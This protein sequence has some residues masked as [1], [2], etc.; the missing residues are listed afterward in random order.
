ML[1]YT[2]TS[3]AAL[4]I[5]LAAPAFA[6]DAAPKAPRAAPVK[7]DGGIPEIVVTAQKRAENVQNVPISITAFT[8]AALTE[9]GVGD[10]AALSAI[11]PNVTLDS[12]T[13]FSGSSAVLGASIRGIGSADF[14]FN[15]D[16]A[17]GVYLD[18]VYLGRSVGANQDLLDVERI[19]V[20]KGPQGTL[21]GRN[22]IGGAVSIVTHDP[23]KE[24][25]FKGDITTGSYNR[26]QVRGTADIP[27][28]DNLTSSI[29][30]SMSRRD[31]YQHRIAYPGTIV[32]DPYTNFVAAGY[33]NGGNRQGG[34]NSYS[35]R[36]KLKY[37]SGGLKAILS[38]DYT[39]INSESTANTLLATTTGGTLNDIYNACATLP[40]AVSTAI[41]NY[42]CG[43]RTSV[44]GFNTAPG[45]AGA[46]Y[47]TYGSQFVTSDK[48]TT[49][50]NG[51][52]YSRVKQYGIG[53]TLEQRISDNAA[54][55]SITAYRQV[56]FNAGV[57]LDG[58]PLNMLQT[59]FTVNQH[60]W[61][62]EFQLNGTSSDKKLNYTFGVY[63]FNEVGGLHDYVTFA[64]GLLQV[65]GPGRINTVALAGYGQID[66]RVSDLIGITVG[67]RYTHER[68]NY[69]GGQ[70]DDNAFGYKISGC[71]PIAQC[72][73]GTVHVPGAPPGVNFPVGGIG[74][75]INNNNSGMFQY[76]SNLG[77]LVQYI[78]Y[79]PSQPNTL[80]FNN[81]SPK[82]GIQL[83]PS[84]HV[85]AY[86]SWS[87]GYRSGGWTTRLSNPLLVAPTFGPEKAQT[88]EVGI[89]SQLADRKLQVN[90]ALFTTNYNGIQL[91]QQ[92]GISPTVANLGI[93]RSRGFEL[94][95]VAAPTRQ[96]T[97]SGSVG[98]LDAKYTYICGENGVF[99]GFCNN[100]SAYVAPDAYRPGIASGM[101]LPKAPKWK[102]NISPR[103]EIETGGG[104]L[105]VLADYTHTSK[106]RNDTEG[107]YLLERRETDIV[108]ASL[109]YKPNNA[110][111]DVTVGGTNITSQRYLITGQAQL[112]GGEIYGT[113][114]RPAEW[115][116]KLGLKF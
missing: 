17:V 56:D 1:K 113:Y 68:K 80:V 22:T 58:S 73:A 26:F 49:Y 27:L 10:V 111:W 69:Y 16:Q 59:S 62:Q 75:P 74:F 2:S 4:A 5:A 51:N 94:E 91:N 87:R 77:G 97:I 13:P 24:F 14:A 48:D 84:E 15:I 11:A 60:Q 82:V 33:N 38:L 104:K 29:S 61:S 109:G 76:G 65:D 83:H 106:Q 37:V 92:I 70:A 63:G 79:Y 46:G 101:P 30:F 6:Q 64:D 95:I 107:T 20:L 57:D 100:N 21:F 35:A 3:M 54:L 99:Q 42:A 72:I 53:L 110:N 85:M 90:A 115:Y 40:T 32:S 55:K 28:A 44:Q 43:P 66:Y 103:Y 88:F 45:I 116:A 86:G 41:F 96:F 8:A 52:N 12:S 34:E 36:T 105:I 93:A 50:A 67:G 78:D 31:G 7:D 9:R 18:G 23:G 102:F 89:K 114:N 108:N 25:H 98:Y 47:S 81:F 112:G 39:N 71:Y 19:E